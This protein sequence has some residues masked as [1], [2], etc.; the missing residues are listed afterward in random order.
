MADLQVKELTLDQAEA[1]YKKYLKADF[2]PE[3]VKPFLII[4]QMWK[5]RN[6]YAYAFYESASE[7]GEDRLCAYAFLTADHEKRVLLLDYFAVCS[8]LRGS[9]YG[10]RALELLREECAQWDGIIVEVEDDELPG[11][12][13]ETRNTR[14]RRIAFYNK[15][16]CHMTTARSILW[17]VEYRIMILPLMDERAQEAAAEKLR[18]VYRCMYPWKILQKHFKITAE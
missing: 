15:A 11:L 10:S 12:E 14:K 4:K 2:P 7:G 8:Q 3:E 6:Y 17:G 1:I 13:E 5:K 9:G 16:G 18:S